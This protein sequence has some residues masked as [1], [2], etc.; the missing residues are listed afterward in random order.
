MDDIGQ[1]YYVGFMIWDTLILRC[2][3]EDPVLFHD[4]EM[5]MSNFYLWPDSEER[6]PYG[7]MQP[8]C[9]FRYEVW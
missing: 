9:R 4:E 6:S 5:N 1:M 8:C 3:I 7:R 2:Q